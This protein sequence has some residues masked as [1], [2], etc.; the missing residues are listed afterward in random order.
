MGQLWYP[1][2]SPVLASIAYTFAFHISVFFHSLFFTCHWNSFVYFSRWRY[3]HPATNPPPLP[4]F[5]IGTRPCTVDPTIYTVSQK[6]LCKIVSVRT[7]S[8]FHQ[9]QYCL[10]DR[11]KNG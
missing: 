5:G 11:W 10:V 6:K 9:F 7:S 4:G 1:G 2:L 8:N 3:L